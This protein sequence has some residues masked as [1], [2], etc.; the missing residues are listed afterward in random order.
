MVRSHRRLWEKPIYSFVHKCRECESRVRTKHRLLE[1][2]SGPAK[3]PHCGDREIQR[4]STRDKIDRT[5]RTPFSVVQSLLGGQLYHCGFCRI[6]FYDLRSG[7][8]QPS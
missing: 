1:Y 3:C 2:V 7:K 6:Q 4:R 5:L 8:R